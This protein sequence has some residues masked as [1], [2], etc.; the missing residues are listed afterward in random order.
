MQDEPKVA[1]SPDERLMATMHKDGL[2]R[3][4]DLE[5][6]INWLRIV[7]YATASWGGIL[8]AFCGCNAL[9]RRRSRL[10]TLLFT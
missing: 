9:I 5:H 10:K 2:I 1:F 4:W 7:G 8:A 6:H 3:I